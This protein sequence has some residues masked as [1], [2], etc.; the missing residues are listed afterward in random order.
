[1]EAEANE[2]VGLKDSRAKEMAVGW[3]AEHA[4]GGR[5]KKTATRPGKQQW[6]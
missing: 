3:G 2:G 6:S 5:G 1:M 4:V